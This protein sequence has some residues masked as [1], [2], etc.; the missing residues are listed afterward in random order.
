M[1][2]IPPTPIV[3]SKL[4]Y[5][6]KRRLEG[7]PVL[8]HVLEKL[9]PFFVFKLYADFRDVNTGIIHVFDP[10]GEF[11]DSEETEWDCI[12]TALNMMTRLKNKLKQ[13]DNRA[14][15]IRIYVKC[16]PE[17]EDK[18]WV[19]MFLDEFPINLGEVKEETK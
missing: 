7:D 5:H 19:D 12:D 13:N 18:K 8:D 4:K 11:I 3:M 9:G 10:I 15:F 1:S 6:I 16:A 14:G 2:L 17:V